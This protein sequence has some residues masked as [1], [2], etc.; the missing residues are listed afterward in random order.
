MELG[1]PLVRLDADRDVEG[2]YR[3]SYP[4]GFTEEGKYRVVFYAQDRSG[5]HAQPKLVT[6]GQPGLY[7]PLLLKNWSQQGF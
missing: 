6:V 5:A 1:V 2:L 3:V 4:G 7:L